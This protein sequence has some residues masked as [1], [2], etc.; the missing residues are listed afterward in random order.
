MW[1]EEVG[2]PFSVSCRCFLYAF[3]SCLLFNGCKKE[4]IILDS[5]S[6]S[7]ES[8]EISSLTIYL[9]QLKI[10]PG[11]GQKMVKAQLVLED[12]NNDIGQYYC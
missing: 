8:I 10:D 1:W 4:L 2:L 3:L 6:I 11:E 7:I 12:N 5:P 9:I